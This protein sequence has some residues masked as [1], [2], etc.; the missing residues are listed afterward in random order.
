MLLNQSQSEKPRR[1]LSH[2][3]INTQ[4]LSGEPSLESRSAGRSKRETFLYIIMPQQ[5]PP[6]SFWWFFLTVHPPYTV[7]HHCIKLMSAMNI[8]GLVFIR[9]IVYLFPLKNRHI[10][11]CHFLSIQKYH[12][13]WCA[14]SKDMLSMLTCVW[15]SELSS[16]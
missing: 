11:S 5:P 3:L 15:H 2:L 8:Q 4:H 16:L 9:F 12:L 6:Q 13:C 10:I 14:W 1:A 7:Y